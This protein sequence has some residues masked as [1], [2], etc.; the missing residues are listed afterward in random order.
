MTMNNPSRS[1]QAQA[2]QA[3]LKEVGLEMNIELVDAPIVVAFWF[4]PAVAYG[5][6]LQNFVLVPDGILRFKDVWLAK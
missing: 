5:E 4:R 6:K 3:Q 2:F 1:Q